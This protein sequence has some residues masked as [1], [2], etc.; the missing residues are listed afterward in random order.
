MKQEEVF[1]KLQEILKKQL[2]V[3]IEIT[4]ETALVQEKVLDSLEFMNY[5]T[6]IE[7]EFGIELSDEDIENKQLGLIKNMVDFLAE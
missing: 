6:T 2:T 5:I 3:D 1:S 7:D 4:P